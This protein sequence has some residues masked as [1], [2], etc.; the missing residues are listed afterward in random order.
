VN[1]LNATREL[2]DGIRAARPGSFS[3]SALASARAAV[4]ARYGGPED[5]DALLDLFLEDP[6]DARRAE[7]PT[8]LMRIGTADTAARLMSACV[9]AGRLKEG[10]AES[11]LHALGF[12]GLAEA[13]DVLWAHARGS[14][15]YEQRAAALGLLNLACDGLESDIEAAIR[16][17]AGKNLFPEFL[18]VLA[19]KAGNPDLLGTI[20]ELGRTIASTDCNGG[21]VYGVAL[22]GERG[23]AHLDDIL[24]DPN[25][26]AFGGGTGTQVWASH[27]FRHLGGS[28]AELARRIRAGA[29]TRTAAGPEYRLCVWLALAECWLDDRL[30]PLRNERYPDE[31]AA[32]VSAAAFDW[33][34]D[35]TDD[36]LTALARADAA[37]ARSARAIEVRLAD[38][39]TAEVF[40]AAGTG[41]VAD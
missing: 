26:E 32:D 38:R 2:V 9:A 15:W 4:V 35:H 29:E 11:V 13:R 3:A 6:T 30:S 39:M 37:L 23:R 7:V 19:H 31:P 27:A 18:P 12:L 41:R 36:S 33:S 28:L 24:F 22:Y 5:A 17:C 14:G 1:V 8:A 20:F 34:S 25:W 10:V 16:N 21:I 40:R